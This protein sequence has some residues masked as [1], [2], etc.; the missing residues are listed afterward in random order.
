MRLLLLL[1]RLLGCLALAGLSALQWQPAARAQGYLLDDATAGAGAGITLNEIA[2][3]SASIDFNADGV[4][5]PTADRIVM[6][7]P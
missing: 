6:R 7:V 3:R 5:S 1:L 4:V 2:A